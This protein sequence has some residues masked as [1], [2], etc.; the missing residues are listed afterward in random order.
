MVGAVF[1]RKKKIKGY[2]LYLAPNEMY[3]LLYHTGNDKDVVIGELWKID[4]NIKRKLDKHEE[5]YVLKKMLKSPIMTYY[6]DFDI[7]HLC[8][9]IPKSKHGHYSFN[10]A[11]NHYRGFY[12]T[13][14]AAQRA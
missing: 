4:K 9:K 6:P 7:K 10:V 8:S 1:L 13:Q 3:P 12:R 14:L 2:V 5:G 11:R